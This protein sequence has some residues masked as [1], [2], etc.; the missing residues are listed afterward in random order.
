M[1][2]SEKQYVAGLLDADGCIRLARQ[3]VKNKNRYDYS[4]RVYITNK[5]KRLMDY[6]KETFG[7]NYSL[8]KDNKN[9]D[10]WYLWYMSSRS[11]I[12]PFL[13][14]ILPYLYIKKEQAI[15]LLEYCNSGI[16]PPSQREDLFFKIKRLKSTGS[17][18]TETY[19][20]FLQEHPNYVA[21]FFDGE[22]Y[23]GVQKTILPKTIRYQLAV[24]I[25]NNEVNALNAYTA[26]YG[27][28][29]SKKG[30]D[31]D[32]YLWYPTNRNQIKAILSDLSPNLVLKKEQVKLGLEYCE[33]PLHAQ[34]PEKREALY[35][36]LQKA[37]QSKIQS[38]LTGDRESA[39][40]ETLAA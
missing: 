8:N 11:H 18:T 32:T 40:M 2:L 12:V 36:E 33:I 6:V 10:D 7:G 28:A 1:I 39:P 24:S 3:K 17:V 30:D 4:P 37:K 23:V 22:G 27:G 14:E 31:S 35:Q 29:V 21:G 20:D 5:S 34:V 16:L 26:L 25:T 15:K 9:G 38:E 19:R 13:N